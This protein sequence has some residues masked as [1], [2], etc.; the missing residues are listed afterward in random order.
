MRK[1]PETLSIG[2]LAE[3]AGVNVVAGTV[4]NPAVAEALGRQ[5]GDLADALAP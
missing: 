2:V 1:T 3:A 4:V 5:C